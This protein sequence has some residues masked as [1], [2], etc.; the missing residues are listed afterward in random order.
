MISDFPTS[1]RNSLEFLCKV[2]GLI[3]PITRLVYSTW[4]LSKLCIYTWM[5]SLR[6]SNLVRTCQAQMT[7]TTPRFE[8]ATLNSPDSPSLYLLYLVL[9]EW[10]NRLRVLKRRDVNQE[11]VLQY[12]ARFSAPSD[13]R[14]WL[15]T[16]LCWMSN[17]SLKFGIIQI[18]LKFKKSLT[19]LLKTYFFT[20]H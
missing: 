4:Y 5:A 3:S 14:V 18:C 7:V 6:W 19:Q 1:A 16:Q 9:L 20:K 13:Q 12:K 17:R 15:I 11:C 2:V 8:H 10:R